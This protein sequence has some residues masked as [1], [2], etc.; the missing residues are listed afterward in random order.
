MPNQSSPTYTNGNVALQVTPLVSKD[1]I[2]NIYPSYQN[3]GHKNGHNQFKIAVEEI[4]SSSLPSEKLDLAKD[5][6]EPIITEKDVADDLIS[7]YLDEISHVS[8]LSRERELAL[9]QKMEKGHVAA[10]KLARGVRSP[11]KAEQHRK[12]VRIG[13]LARSELIESNYRLVVSIT[14]KYI[15][16]GVSFMDLIQEG[17]IGLIKAVDKF[18]YHRGYKFSTYA[19]WWIRQA[20]TRAIAD[21]ARTIR[22]P[23]HMY[24]RIN[25]ISRVKRS[26][27]QKL[28]QEPTIEELATAMD[29]TIEGIYQIYQVAQ[30]PLSL[31]MPIG[32]EQESN[33]GDFIEDGDSMCLSESSSYEVLREKME[34]IL[35]SLSAKEGR[36]IQ[37]RFGLHDGRAYTLEEVGRKFGVTRERIRQIESSALRKLRH[38]RRSRCL[39]EFL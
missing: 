6:E 11:T 5:D 27:A 31:E 16:Q 37:L 34:N 36:V 17:N 10:K 32:E 14:K 8:L 7:V 4:K 15:S 24:E 1:A 18:D 12:L 23:V 29:T 38:P 20:V 2:Q 33:L 25:K 35:D 9:A 28:G 21:Q 30:H 39:K 26:L 22:V 19:T 3:N 13:E